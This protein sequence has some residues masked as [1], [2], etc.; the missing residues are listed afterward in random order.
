MTVYDQFDAAARAYAADPNPTTLL[1]LNRRA[2]PLLD[3]ARQ[4]HAW[5]PI[6]APDALA[7][8][9]Y[10][11]R[12]VCDRRLDA[13]EVSRLSGCL[14]Y[15]LRCTLA[16]EDL[17]DPTVFSLSD[18]ATT[19]TVLDFGYDATKSRR[20]DP[21]FQGAFDLAREMIV[22]GTPIRTTNRAG[23]G[24]RGTRLVDGIGPIR[25]LFYVR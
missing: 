17:T 22:S 10:A 12:V 4:E 20:S 24:T 7:G 3:T 11:V 2:L 6:D 19:F 8:D 25:L 13:E 23:W 15:A 14:G 21:D 18:G 16:G 5:M 1:H 9:F